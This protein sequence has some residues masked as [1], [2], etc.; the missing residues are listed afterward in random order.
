MNDATPLPD[1]AALLEVLQYIAPE[2][3]S[4]PTAVLLSPG[5]YN[6]AYFEHIMDA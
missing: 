2:S 6:S 5:M 1:P 3:S 4:Q